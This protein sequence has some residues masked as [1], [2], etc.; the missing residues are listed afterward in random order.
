MAN[1]CDLR[2]TRQG[3]VPHLPPTFSEK[4][5]AHFNNSVKFSFLNRST[6]SV[7]SWDDLTI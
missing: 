7:W 5:S 1:K 6:A 2:G 3:Q 4:K